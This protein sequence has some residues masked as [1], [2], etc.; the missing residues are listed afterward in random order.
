MEKGYGQSES[1]FGCCL[2]VLRSV[3]HVMSNISCETK[4]FQ[5]LFLGLAEPPACRW[6]F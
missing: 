6:A 5:A 2:L 3:Q 4:M 1:V